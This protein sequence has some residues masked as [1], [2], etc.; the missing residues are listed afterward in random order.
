MKTVPTCLLAM[1][2]IAIIS[3][4]ENL[5]Q[6]PT[7]TSSENQTGTKKAYRET[8][9]VNGVEIPVIP[10]LTAVDVHGNM[11]KNGF[12]TKKNIRAKGSVW[13]CKMKEDANDYSVVITGN[14]PYK[15]TS[16]EATL[17]NFEGVDMDDAAEFLSYVS[18]LSYENASPEMAQAWVNRWAET[19]GDTTIGGVR[20]RIITRYNVNR[21]L[22]ISVPE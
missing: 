14:G 8:A 16:V 21:T 9:M 20:F 13:T 3:C 15:I 19:G 11:E 10:G 4:G 2:S 22:R 5:T 18:S 12:T 6:A 17:R 1:V 7:E